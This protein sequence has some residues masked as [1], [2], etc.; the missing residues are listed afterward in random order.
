MEKRPKKKKNLFNK[1]RWEN[2]STM[3][4]R[5]KPTMRYHLM[6]VR[7]DTIKSLLKKKIW[8][9]CGEKGTLLHC[10]WDCKLGQALWRTVWR[11]VKKLETYLP[12]DLTIPLLGIHAKETRIKTKTKTKTHVPQCSSQHSL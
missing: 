8:R 5:L 7:M 6:H 1:W 10:W 3:C 2:W 12:Y 11:L 9:R 4:K